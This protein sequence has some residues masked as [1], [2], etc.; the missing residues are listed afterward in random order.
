MN[1]TTLLSS[2][3]TTITSYAPKDFDKNNLITTLTITSSLSGNNNIELRDI[4]YTSAYVESLKEDEIEKTLNKLEL[5][6]E[7]ETN[8]TVEQVENYIE[9]INQKVKTMK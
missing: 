6:L 8:K 1:L 2:I 7:E 4:E 9:D 3:Y 5:Y